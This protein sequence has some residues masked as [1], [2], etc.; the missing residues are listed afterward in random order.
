MVLGRAQVL[1]QDQ[2]APGVPPAEEEHAEEHGHA[3]QPSRP[4]QEEPQAGFAA[5][6]RGRRWWRDGDD[7]VQGRSGVERIYTL[8]L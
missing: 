8:E 5:G 1:R 2:E 7:G 6:S 4:E 3:A